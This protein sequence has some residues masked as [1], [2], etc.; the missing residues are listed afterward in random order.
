MRC[1]SVRN[2]KPPCEPFTM[3]QRDAVGPVLKSKSGNGYILVAIDYLT[4]WPMV[5]AVPNINETTTADF[6]YNVVVSNYGVPNFILTDRGSDLTSGYIQ[7]FLQQLG[8]RHITTTAYR[9]QTNGLCERMNQTLVQTLAK[10]INERGT[11]DCWDEYVNSALLAIRTMKNISTGHTAG[12]LLFGYEMRTPG[13]WPAPRED[14]VE[15]NLVEEVADRV[16]T[17]SR[18]AEVYR[19]MARK[20]VVE[21]QQERAKRYNLSVAPR[22]RYKIGEQTP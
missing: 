15:G 9:S 6:L 17:V 12:K 2:I 21:K 1:M 8:C 10:I 11:E 3:I 7:S 20:K 16:V 19:I 5:L 18:L 14:F 13:T 22:Q 4:K